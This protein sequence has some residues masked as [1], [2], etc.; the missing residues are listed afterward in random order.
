M[1]NNGLAEHHGVEDMV[2][3]P[4]RI[5]VMYRSSSLMNQRLNH[6]LTSSLSLSRNKHQI[7]SVIDVFQVSVVITAIFPLLISPYIPTLPP[8]TPTHSFLILMTCKCNK[9]HSISSLLCL[10][11]ISSPLSHLFY[12]REDI[13]QSQLPKRR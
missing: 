6:N 4:N 3:Y 8:G 7:Q 5:S 2:R 12:E 13:Q 1:S 10:S 11:C 9:Q